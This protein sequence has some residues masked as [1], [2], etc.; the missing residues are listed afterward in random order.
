MFISAETCL[1]GV[2]LLD[3]D[4]VAIEKCYEID[5]ET[6]IGIAYL[7]GRP[8]SNRLIDFTVLEFDNGRV[9]RCRCEWVRPIKVLSPSGYE[10]TSNLDMFVASRFANLKRVIDR[11]AEVAGKRQTEK[12]WAI[13]CELYAVRN[14]LISV[15]NMLKNFAVS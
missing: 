11:K 2:S 14:Q 9:S 7:D 6:G 12:F 13:E 4:G 15:A 5:T 1:I 3:G 10:I 8:I